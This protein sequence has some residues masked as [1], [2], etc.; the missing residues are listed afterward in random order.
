MIRFFNIFCKLKHNN[1]F[2]KDLFLN[3]IRDFSPDKI[4]LLNHPCPFCGTKKPT[5]TY[6]NSYKRYLIS[7]ENNSVVINTVVIPRA[8]CSS[9]KHTHAIL[10]EIIVPHSSY[11]LVFI[12]TV[13]KEY[14]AKVNI[15]KI[16]ENYQISTSTL[17]LWKNL[18]LMHKRLWLGIL[19]NIYQDSMVFLS[20]IPNRETSQELSY[21]FNQTGYSFLQG[22]SKTAH[23]S[24][25]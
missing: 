6:H 10:P 22:I 12:L 15:V 7:Y 25:A 20:S 1:Y 19:E 24:S 8:M 16:C 21:F 4:P 23:F 2:V 5:W 11:S 14:F 9:C 18:F 3:F 13:L 17:Y